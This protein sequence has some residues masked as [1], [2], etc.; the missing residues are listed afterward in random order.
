MPAPSQLIGQTISHYRVVE[1]L[2]GGGMGVV[3]KAEDT[4]LHRFVALKFLPEN[5]ARD[6]Q[7]LTRFRREAQAASALNHPNICTIHDIGEQEGQ[8]FIA[9]EF[10]DG[11]TLK[12]RI[13]NRPMDTELILSLAIEIADALDAAHAEGIVHRDVKPANIFVTKRENAK[14]L[15][16]GLAKVLPV[17]RRMMEGA[18]VSAEATA[19][20]EEHLTSPG[21]TLGTVAYMSPEQARGKELDARTDLFSF[22]AVLYE[23][24]TGAVPFHGET[25]AV[26]FDAILNSDPPPPIR[27]NR[28]IPAK[29]EDII[30]KALEKD[31][32]LRYQSAGDIVT[33]LKRLKRDTDSSRWKGVS[34]AASS[35]SAVPVN[36]E[37][38]RLSS[39]AVILA[40]AR[41]HKGKLAVI[42]VG[43]ALLLVLLGIYWSRFRGRGSEWNLQSMKISR[44]TQS[45]NASTVAISPDGHYVA[46]SLLEGEKQSL[47][48]R[49]VAT[50]SD[51]QILPPEEVMIWGLTFSPDANYIDFVRSEKNN[52]YNT[53]LYRMPVLGGT[54][55]LITRGGADSVNSYS[56]DGTHFAYLR[57]GENLDLLIAI[58]KADGSDE[59]VLAT[60]P[61]RVF[62]GTAWSP[63]GKTIAFSTLD[64]MKGLRFVLWDVSVSNGSTREIYSA[65][66][67]IGRPR[68]LPDGSGLLV[69]ISDRLQAFRSQLWFVSYPQGV[70]RRLTNDLLDYQACCLDLTRDGQ[71]LVDTEQTR[72]SN[73]WIAPRGDASRAKQITTAD[74]KVNS[75]SWMPDG[76]I[77]VADE[78]GNIL[79]VKPDGSGRT[80]LTSNQQLNS[81]PSVCGDGRYVV[82]TSYREQK[83]GIWRM[84]PD[85]SN[86]VRIADETLAQGPLCSPDGK[87][88]VY[89]RG[90]DGF[91]MRVSTDGEKPAQMVAQDLVALGP[92][93]ATH[94]PTNAQISPDGKLIAYVTWNNPGGPGPSASKP[95]V[96]KVISLDGG[97]PVHQFDWPALA[98]SWR[99]APTGDA[100]QYSLTKHGVSN[101]WEQKLTG[102]AQ[103]Q[104]TNFQS[105]MI[106]DFS[107]SPDAKQLALTRGSNSSD[108]ILISNVR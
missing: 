108:V 79:S 69:T 94:I 1:Q 29:L 22:G 87:W 41:R 5:V 82:F 48:V 2:G 107:W 34:D 26:I 91:L 84:D 10:L 103:K 7:A 38:S 102:G 78:D 83:H 53:F 60:S 45:G 51:V 97:A 36:P 4:R 37:T 42:L 30:N 6:P 31:R 20:S 35:I 74:I 75:F 55:H 8:A 24:A 14:I 98:E 54:P 81:S 44:V 59:R 27:F 85:G 90:P 12:H 47:N 23:M 11:V 43:S 46:Y 65:P 25:S 93:S 57:V 28:D 39:G 17:T 61:A 96:L 80:L 40:E 64:T 71:T 62:L 3:Y 86:Q 76:D 9:M 21:A 106:L 100:L 105:G 13:G 92:I 18:G 15:D 89:Q 66:G 99:W 32:N 19:E 70:A 33:D 58:A 56:P 67:A 73:L 77:V 72:V 101:L 16:F 68:W 104:I 95:L 88:V 63:D 50:G 49:Q 52:L